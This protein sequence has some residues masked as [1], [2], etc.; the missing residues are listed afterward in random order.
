MWCNRHWCI[1]LLVYILNHHSSCTAKYIEHHYNKKCV[2]AVIKWY[3]HKKALPLGPSRPLDVL[4]LRT[5]HHIN[6]AHCLLYRN[7]HIQ[8]K[9]SYIS[10][11][12]CVLYWY[13]TCVVVV[14]RPANAPAASWTIN[15]FIRD[16]IFLICFLLY[17]LSTWYLLHL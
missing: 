10:L 3:G 16:A 1:Y 17:H 2:T 14:S 4:L 5:Y 9:W 6:N 12:C 11:S 7:V 13:Y 8:K 15:Y